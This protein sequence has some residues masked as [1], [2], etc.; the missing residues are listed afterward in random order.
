MQVA[1]GLVFLSPSGISST[2][3]GILHTVLQEVGGSAQENG[4]SAT[5]QDSPE[6]SSMWVL[7]AEAA[8]PRCSSRLLEKAS[9]AKSAL[10]C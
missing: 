1:A 6:W 4:D 2:W 8:F 9:T 3:D 10:N 5:A 7:R